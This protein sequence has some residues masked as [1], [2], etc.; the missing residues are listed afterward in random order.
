MTA[1]VLCLKLDGMK[2][3]GGVR[4]DCVRGSLLHCDLHLLALKSEREIMETP[5][6]RR[7][8]TWTIGSAR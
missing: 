6:K 8:C 1:E 2:K 7:G 3:T 5:I 4:Q